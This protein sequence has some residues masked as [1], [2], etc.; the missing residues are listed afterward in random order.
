MQ[1]SRHSVGLD[2]LLEPGALLAHAE[3]LDQSCERPTPVTTTIP[4]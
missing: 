1:V 3:D 4:R 2:P